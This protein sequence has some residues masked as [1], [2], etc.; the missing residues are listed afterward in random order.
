MKMKNKI[1]IVLISI[2]L[3][4]GGV[5]T[6]IWYHASSKLTNMYLQNVSESSM[7]DAYHAFEYI[8]TDTSYMATMVS[9]N[10]S[11]IIEP[12]L[13][14]RNNKIKENNQWNQIY[15]ENR[16]KILEYLKSVDGYKYYISGIS[17]AVD[18]DCIFSANHVIRQDVNLYDNI[19]EL[20]QEKLKTTVVMMEPMHMEGL[21]STVTSDYVVPAV[22]AI[23]DN[24]KNIIGYVIVYFDYGVIDQMFSASLPEGSYF[25]VVNDNDSKIY[26][27]VEKLPLQQ[28]ESYISNSFYAENVGW[29]FNMSIPSHYYIAG[30]QRTTI[31]TGVIIIVIII[32][33]VLILTVFV[34]RV[35]TEITVLRNKMKDVSKGNLT[36][37]YE[38]KEN[39]EIGQ[40]GQTF[41]KMVGRISEL[42]EKVTAEEREKRLAE[43]AF[44][45]AQINPHFISNVLN[46]V[47][48]MAK[49]QHADNIVP[50]VNSLNFLLRA[51]MHEDK[52]LISLKNELEYVDNYL[53]IMEY[54]GSYDFQIVRNIDNDTMELYV[55]RFILQPI[56]ENA[57]YHGLSTDI[58]KQG[59]ITIETGIREENLE[60]CIADNGDGMSSEEIQK[61]L[62]KKGKNKKSFN[63][64]G[65]GNVNERIKLCFGEQYGLRYESELG[66]YTRCIF[67]LPVVR[68]VENNGE[69]Q[70]CYS[71]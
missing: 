27:N 29:T 22:R 33:A 55:P 61:V 25:E 62:N 12:V 7:L 45:Q 11:N 66:K 30:I 32:I 38:V 63:G 14:L 51:V 65:I 23:T 13:S 1:I 59:V 16:R 4:S 44:L 24:V 47:V 3:F 34:S 53:T 10:E 43:M 5:I 60:I 15:L 18:R 52:E 50:L 20:D 49:I 48:W 64:V 31:L 21:K 28:S 2:L 46:N 42:M 68:E 57:I 39:D 8:L 71:R 41:N 6:G 56:V 37:R 26:A 17:I 9:Q 70:T 58:S 54:S 19:Q 69:D 40:M 67:V 36:V 35:T